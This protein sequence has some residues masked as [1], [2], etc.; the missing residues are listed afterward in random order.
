MTDLLLTLPDPPRKLDATAAAEWRRAGRFLVRGRMLAV[1]DLGVLEAY[2]R[3][4]ARLRRLED[5][6]EASPLTD[7]RGRANPL[8]GA[9][10]TTAAALAKMA[11]LLGVSPI[12]RTR[13]RKDQQPKDEP[14]DETGLG[15]ILEMR[16]RRGK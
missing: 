3:L 6:I 13:M 11:S 7:E 16:R 10:N 4:F 15:A 12:T 1:G 2:A 5:Q 14:A 9:G 8:I